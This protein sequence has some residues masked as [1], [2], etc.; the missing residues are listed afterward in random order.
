MGKITNTVLATSLAFSALLAP[1]TL[2]FA[3][4]T[5]TTQ[6]TQATEQSQEPNH[7]LKNTPHFKRKT[8]LKVS[9]FSKGL[10]SYNLAT[11]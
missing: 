8:P 11:R 2:A 3:E 5:D 9:I 6:A 1:S 4:T 7:K 10:Y